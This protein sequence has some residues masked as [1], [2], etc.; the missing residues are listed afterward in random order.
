MLSS[1]LVLLI[2]LALML[3]PV[4]VPNAIRTFTTIGR[5]LITAKLTA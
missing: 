3:C 5:S 1:T 2:S 4:D